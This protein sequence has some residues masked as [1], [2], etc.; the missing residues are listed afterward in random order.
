MNHGMKTLRSIA[1]AG[2]LAVAA[3]GLAHAADAPTVADDPVL[4]KR[5][6]AI[7]EELRCLVCQ[8]QTIADSH[9]G[10]AVDLK[11]QI[12]EQLKAGKTDRQILDYM[13]ER[14]GD[15]VLYRPPMKT[16]TV[17]LWAG[18]FALM[19]IGLGAAGLIVR[20][21]RRPDHIAHLTEEQRRHAARLLSDV[22]ETRS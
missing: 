16:T 18:P 1:S 12:R 14:Y 15:F 21:R 2:L 19:A 9:A 8:N 17:L 7:G 13:V 4:E 10:L 6:N 22:P 5:V 11:N 20:R 3:C